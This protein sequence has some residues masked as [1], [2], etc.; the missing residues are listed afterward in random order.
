MNQAG[1]SGLS[2]L[3]SSRNESCSTSNNS[4]RLDSPV[5]VLPFN[6]P[7]PAAFRANPHPL[8]HLT[9]HGNQSGTQLPYGWQTTK[10]NVKERFSSILFKETLADVHF[11]VGRKEPID[12]VPGHKFMLSV[13]SAVFDALFNGSMAT[14]D[15]EIEIPDVEAEAFRSLLKFLYT[16]MVEIEPETVMA[17]LYAAKKYS[18]PALERQCV[19]FLK[20]NLKPDNAFMLLT[21]A[22]LFDESALGQLCLEMIDKHTADALAASGF[23]DID[24]DTLQ[25]VI[26]RDSLRIREV[27]LFNDV[28]RWAEAEC[29]RQRLPSNP[30]NQR[31]VLGKSLYLIRFPLMTVEE[32]AA[33]V[34]Q[35]GLLSDREV[36]N[37]FLQFTLN[38]KPSIDLHPFSDVARCSMTG[39]RADGE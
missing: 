29:Q 27:V 5:E 8:P 12:R 3:Q 38:E 19:D 34:A 18:V 7:S 15:S 1:V 23:L 37:L 33:E 6:A 22:R 13:G 4:K 16:D 30:E 32:F 21:Q 36:V 25:L 28:V 9:Y 39:K 2:S 31:A 35:S 11:L 20:S 26:Q 14:D 17:T 10:N 24:Y